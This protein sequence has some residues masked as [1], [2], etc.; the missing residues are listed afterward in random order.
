MRNVILARLGHRFEITG[1]PYVANVGDSYSYTFGTVGG[2]GTIT[3]TCTSLGTSGATFSA[4]T[5]S[6]TCANG[7][8]FPFTLTARDANRQFA[9]ADFELIIIGTQAF[10]MCLEGSPNLPMQIE[11]AD[12]EMALQ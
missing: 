5:L 10:I 1:H 4:G 7:G 3:W 8:T 6:G 11:G 12:S 2:T 9:T